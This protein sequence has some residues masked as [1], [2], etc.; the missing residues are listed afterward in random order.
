M[1]KSALST[2]L[3]LSVSLFN[4]TAIFYNT[5]TLKQPLRTQWISEMIQNEIKKHLKTI[6]NCSKPKQDKQDMR[7]L[8]ALMVT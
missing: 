1:E 3:H 8:Q 7:G 5:I 4:N 6:Q 2:D